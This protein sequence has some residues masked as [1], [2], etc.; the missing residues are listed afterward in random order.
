MIKKVLTLISTKSRLYVM[1]LDLISLKN[2]DKFVDEFNRKFDIKRLSR[3]ICNAGIWMPMKQNL[4]S[5][6]GF[7]LHFGVHHLA[8]F[9]LVQ[10]LLDLHKG[11]EIPLRVIFVASDLLQFGN[12]DMNS[13]D[14]LHEGRPQRPGDKAKFAPTGY[15]DAK[16]AQAICTKEFS[17][18]HVEDEA[19][20]Y[21]VSPGLCNTDLFRE[22]KLPWILRPFEGP[23]KAAIRSAEK[24]AQNILFVALQPKDVLK[25]GLVYSNA[26]LFKEGNDK[27]EEFK[28]PSA[29]FT[30]TEMQLAN[31]CK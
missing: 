15:V 6:E 26:K 27:V 30:L 8:H 24:G 13:Q 31:F 9:L 23:V 21:C 7:E 2:V 20:F 11:S 18:R 19:L 4:K 3:V 28:D 10:K 17:K 1:H 22:V 12:I 29:F 5:D 16:L 25:N 14:F